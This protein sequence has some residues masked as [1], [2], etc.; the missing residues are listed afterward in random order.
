MRDSVQRSHSDRKKRHM[1]AGQ[2][3]GTVVVGLLPVLACFLGGGTQKWAEGIVLAV[4]GL[5]MLIWPPRVS[6]GAAT[7]CIFAALI[8]LGAIAFLPARWFF[9]PAWRKPMVNAVTISLPAT[10]MPQP[11]ITAPSLPL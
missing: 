5:Y 1:S 6:L 8:A 3:A 2:V 7:N 10:R 4:L 9:L 11:L